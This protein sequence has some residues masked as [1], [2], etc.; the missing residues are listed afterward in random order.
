MRH[1]KTTKMSSDESMS[2]EAAFMSLTNV[3]NKLAKVLAEVVDSLKERL[4]L[5]SPGHQTSLIGG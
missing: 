5:H 3:K 2:S 1:E 4:A